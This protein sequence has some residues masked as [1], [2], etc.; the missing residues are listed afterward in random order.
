MLFSKFSF[1]AILLGTSFFSALTCAAPATEAPSLVTRQENVPDDATK[2]E[3]VYKWL[4]D[5]DIDPEDSFV[6]YTKKEGREWSEKFIEENGDFYNYWSIFNNDFIEDF[7]QVNI[8]DEDVAKTLS[9]AMAL[10]AK[11]DTYVFNNDNADDDSYWVLERSI[12]LQNSKVDAIYSMNDGATDDDDYKE[13]LKAE[14][15][16]DEMEDAEDDAEDIIE[17]GSELDD[18]IED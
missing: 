12:L 18:D 10:F 1:S 11:G 14:A 2:L 6:F 13:D 7:G 4:K 16:D 15:S 17:E 9:K 3:K 5:S 8:E